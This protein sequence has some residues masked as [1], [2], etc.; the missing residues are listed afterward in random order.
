M[1]SPFSALSLSLCPTVC[2]GLS[3]RL[4]QCAAFSFSKCLSQLKL[5]KQTLLERVQNR[6][7]TVSL[8]PF[9][10]KRK[11]FSALIL[12]EAESPDDNLIH[13][14]FPPKTTPRFSLSLHQSSA[15]LISQRIQK[16]LLPTF[17]AFSEPKRWN[18]VFSHQIARNAIFFFFEVI[19][20]ISPSSLCLKLA[21]GG[22]LKMLPLP[23]A[24]RD[25]M[26]ARSEAGCKW[27]L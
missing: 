1:Q 3:S 14:P 5:L 19:F 7:P 8:K 18:F 23:Y 20:W 13:I 24:T 10:G 17:S 2:C 9:R 25:K 16:L 15:F 27:C 26:V 11:N 6:A 21:E 12:D 4:L 22:W